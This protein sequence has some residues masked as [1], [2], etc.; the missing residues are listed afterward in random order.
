M[1]RY[2]MSFS[3]FSPP[4]LF[5]VLPNALA[6]QALSTQEIVQDSF[7]SSN[8]EKSKWEPHT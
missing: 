3:V 4:V 6:Q 5:L 8:E 1:S 7:N 2:V